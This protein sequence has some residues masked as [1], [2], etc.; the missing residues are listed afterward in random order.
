MS[1]INEEFIS[2][3]NYIQKRRHLLEGTRRSPEQNNLQYQRPRLVSIATSVTIFVTLFDD[4][5]VLH[6]K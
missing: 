5:F 6:K 4:F 2:Q 1:C 3:V